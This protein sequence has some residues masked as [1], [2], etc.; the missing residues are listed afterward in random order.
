MVLMR[1]LGE[2]GTVTF[3]NSL[4]HGLD[5]KPILRMDVPVTEEV[6]G[7]VFIFVLGWLFGVV[8]AGTYNLLVGEK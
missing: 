4:M 8:V 5:V 2:S 3:F 7:V 1:L 6:M